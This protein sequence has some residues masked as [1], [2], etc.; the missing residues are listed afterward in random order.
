MDDLYKAYELLY[1]IDVQDNELL[2][3]FAENLVFLGEYEDINSKLEVMGNR[4]HVM[5]MFLINYQSRH[6]GQCQS[7]Y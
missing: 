6:P 2:E 7:R 3:Q 5:R 1:G 4:I